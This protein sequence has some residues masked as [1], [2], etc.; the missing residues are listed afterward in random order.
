MK[1]VIA[2]VALVATMAASAQTRIVS[3]DAFDFSYTGGLKFQSQKPSSG[4]SKVKTN[5]FRFNLNYAQSLTKYEGV[6][7]KGKFHFNRDDN[8]G[9]VMSAFGIMGGG[10]YNFQANDVKNSIFAGAMIGLE[11]ATV[12]LGN[13]DES[14]FNFMLFLEAGKR[15]DMGSYAKINASYAP[16]VSLGFTRYGGGIRKHIYKNSSDFRLNFLKFDILF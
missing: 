3:I 10:L 7:W 9:N 16:S 2:I 5:E 4:G 6:M 15:W 1:A 12:E 13:D 14:G 8:D 11:R